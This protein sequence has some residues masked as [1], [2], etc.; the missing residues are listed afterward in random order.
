MSD[1]TEQLLQVLV[2]L[3]G[4][5]AFSPDKLREIVA[6]GQSAAR[7]VEAYNL[8]DGRRTQGD[9][10][11]SLRLDAG[12]FSRTVRRW[13]DQGIVFR[14]GDDQQ[15]LHLYPLTDAE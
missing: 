13:Q 3:A 5:T 2:Q 7:Q 12:N 14:V 15:L 9:I 1:R 11:K 4:R 8:C 10:A 6:V